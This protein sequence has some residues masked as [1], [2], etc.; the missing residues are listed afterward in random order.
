VLGPNHFEIYVND[1]DDGVD[2][3]ILKFADDTKLYRRI[4]NEEDV[5]QLQEDI[6]LLCKWSREWFMLFN[7]D[8]CKILHLGHGIKMVLYTING[9]RVAGSARGSILGY[10]NSR[11]S[12]MG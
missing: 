3:K 1:I 2:S 9:G 5:A 11:G 4:A 7:V 8:K 12:Y 10:C 6:A